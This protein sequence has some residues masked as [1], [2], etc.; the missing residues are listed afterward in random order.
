MRKNRFIWIVL[1]IVLLV[2]SVAAAVLRKPAGPSGSS[3][4]TAVPASIALLASDVAQVRRQDLRQILP[5]SGTL[6]ASR[7]ASVKARVGGEVRE[8]L[9]REGEA[10]QAGQILVKIDATEYLARA[11]Q[12]RGAL[13]AARAQ[14]DIA[15]TSRNNN[16][17]LIEKGFISKNAFENA[18]SQLDIA[19]ANVDSAKATLDVAQKS[20][21]DTT[22]R[23][24]IAGLASN[25]V[26]E[27]GEKVSPDAPLL[28]IVDLRRME[29][30]AAV[31]T[32]EIQRIAVGQEV[33]VGVGGVTTPFVGNVARIDPST[34]AGS[35]SIV[36]YVEINNPQTILRAGM[37]GEG[38]LTLLRR[39]AVLTVPA[40]AVQSI[41]G[42]TTV[43]VIRD[44]SLQKVPVTLGIVGDVEGTD[45]LEIISGVE[46]GTT[47]IRNNLGNFLPGTRVAVEKPVVS[48]TR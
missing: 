5:L 30:Q 6:R 10:V 35:R 28:D 9:V 15:T 31:P 4:A 24:P 48:A 34:Q 38:R 47:I 33:R 11:A 23:A 39:D 37:F 17:A 26:I 41:D 46:E 3:A 1:L 42:K 27:P 13:A 22:V 29:M 18:A 7:Q 44:G 43:Y 20:V 19:Q 8:V 16:R 45:T 25:R 21:S 2:A 40:S 12:A 36:V 14:L 32:N